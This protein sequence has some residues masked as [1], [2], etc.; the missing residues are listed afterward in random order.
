MSD[1]PWTP[2]PWSWGEDYSYPY[3]DVFIDDE[4]II[5]EVPSGPANA[6]L[7]AASPELVEA[8]EGLLNENDMA[9]WA[10]KVTSARALLAR[11]RGD[12]Q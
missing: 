8:L 12:D 4:T 5:A 1:T 11:I 3:C 7:I 9:G 6:R 2:G 10:A